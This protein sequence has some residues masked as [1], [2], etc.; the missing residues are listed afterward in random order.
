MYFVANAVRRVQ[1]RTKRAV[2]AGRARFTQRICGN[3][4][5]LVRGRY[6]P[7]TEEE[8]KLY[9]EELKAK[10]KEGLIEVRVGA[11]KGSLYDFGT[12]EPAKAAVEEPEEEEVLEDE[13]EEAEE[14][15]PDMSWTKSQLVSHAAEVLDEDLDYLKGLTKAE[16]LEKL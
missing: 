7:L 8:F 12:G 15:A 16:I 6:V 2:N 4:R 13:P 5:R 1:T 14:D 10:N 9:F 11:V 3:T